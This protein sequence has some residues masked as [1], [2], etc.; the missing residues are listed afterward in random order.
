M[1]KKNYSVV[2]VLFLMIMTLLVGCNGNITTKNTEDQEN[3]IE[4]TNSQSDTEINFVYTKNIVFLNYQYVPG[5]NEEKFHEDEL[6]TKYVVEEDDSTLYAFCVEATKVPNGA[7]SDIVGK[8]VLLKEGFVI[9]ENHPEWP[10]V[11][12]GTISDLRRVFTERNGEIDGWRFCA[13]SVHRPDMCDI[14]RQT[15]WTEEY[16]RETWFNKHY[17]EIVPLLGTD[18][19][20]I[21]LTVPVTAAEEMTE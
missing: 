14:L 10:L 11:I 4:T 8:E 15:G 13:V 1:E 17:E 9:V 16:D 2:I 21:M 3:D 12:A 18:E 7:E 19:E 20:Q 5:M 6:H